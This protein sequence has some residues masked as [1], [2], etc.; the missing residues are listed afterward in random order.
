M[1]NWSFLDVSVRFSL[2]YLQAPPFY[3]TM[4]KYLQVLISEFIS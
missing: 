1:T 4:I 3:H 2:Y